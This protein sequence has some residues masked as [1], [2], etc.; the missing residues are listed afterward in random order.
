MPLKP[1]PYQVLNTTRIGR[2]AI[3]QA[4][5]ATPYGPAPYTV[6]RMKPFA[7]CAAFVEGRL[8]CVRQYRYAVETY[9]WEL[10]GG[11]IEVGEDPCDAAARELREETGLCARELFSLGTTFTSS[12]STDEC[13]HLFAARCDATVE[14]RA[15]DRGEQVELV[16][17]E[18]A[19]IERLIDEGAPIHPELYVVWVKLQRQGL[20]DQLFAH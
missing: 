14:D 5:L 1:Y 19:E 18:R 12:G 9:M 17:L 16:L 15:L 2:F 4:E 11:V 3:E 6:A 8:A 13:C 10:P 20:L 7:C